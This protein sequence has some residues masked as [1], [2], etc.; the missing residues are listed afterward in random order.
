MPIHRPHP[1]IPPTAG[2]LV[3]ASANCRKPLP[4]SARTLPNL[5]STTAPPPLQKT[6]RTRKPYPEP[7]HLNLA[8]LLAF[9][10]GPPSPILR[11]AAR[12]PLEQLANAGKPI[13]HR[14]KCAPPVSL[15]VQEGTAG[16]S[17]LETT[18]H[19]SPTASNPPRG[20]E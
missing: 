9:S 12:L 19:D 20:C 4:R 13:W 10:L 1:A 5:S 8:K 3:Q 16:T 7:K 18:G 17:E 14:S 2:A 6:G 15:S 11:C